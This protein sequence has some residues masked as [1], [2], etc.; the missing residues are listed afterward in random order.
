MSFKCY[1]MQCSCM[2]SRYTFASVPNV[3]TANFEAVIFINKKSNTVIAL[4][5]SSH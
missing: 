1:N 4:Q 2:Y 5:C 3:A